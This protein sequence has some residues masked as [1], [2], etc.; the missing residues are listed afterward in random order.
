VAVIFEICAEGLLVGVMEAE[1]VAAASGSDR[2]DDKEDDCLLMENDL[3]LSD[4]A[5][6]WCPRGTQWLCSA[7]ACRCDVTLRAPRFGLRCCG[8]AVPLCC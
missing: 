2:E 4:T 6:H 3:V 8:A 5:A 7:R 1:D